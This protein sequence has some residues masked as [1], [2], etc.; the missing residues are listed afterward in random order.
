MGKTL[1]RIL[2]V[3]LLLVLLAFLVPSATP[4]AIGEEAYPVYSPVTL[5]AQSVEPIDYLADTPY[6]PGKNNYLPDK[7]GY[8]DPSISVRVETMRAYDTTI[9]LTWVQIA[10]A[11]QL[12]SELTKPY[13]SKSTA[14]GDTL[15]KRVNAVLAI[16]D[17]WFMHRKEGFIVRN[18]EVLRT[19][20]SEL[21]DCLIIDDKGDL[22]IILEPTEEKINAFEGKIV[23]ALAFGPGLVMDGVKREDFTATGPGIL[24]ECTPTKETQRIALCQMDTLS[25]LIVATEGPENKGSTGLTMPEFAQL[26]YDLGAKQAFN[27][28]GGSSSTVV[29]NNKKINSLSTGKIRA[30]GGILYFVTAVPSEGSAE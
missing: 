6:A 2:A 7:A 16:N 22:H 8:V 27:L 25:Y 24:K 30:I 18:G 17:D 4:L 3:V 23:Q 12:R 10:D 20:Y 26:C 9:Q 28:D 15:S 13:P 29:L 14:R 1:I 19:N 5:E 11:S 21:Y